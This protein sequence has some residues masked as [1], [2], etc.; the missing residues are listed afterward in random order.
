MI[1]ITTPCI[2][3]I[4]TATIITNTTDTTY[5]ATLASATTGTEINEKSS[6]LFGIGHF[7]ASGLLENPYLTIEICLVLLM[8]FL[9]FYIY[10]YIL[11]EL[12][13]D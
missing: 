1:T 8:L 3:T 2:T 13:F 6:D 7:Q 10:F 11:K 5:I 12:S 9:L 4:A